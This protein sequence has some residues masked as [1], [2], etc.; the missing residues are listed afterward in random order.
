M[1]KNSRTVLFV[2]LLLI[3]LNAPESAQVSQVENVPNPMETS[4]LY[5]QDSAGV[6]GPDYIEM[7]DQVCQ[8]LYEKA[9][10]ELAV[11]T[12][13]SLE[14]ISIEEFALRLFE[15]F[16]IGKKRED[17]GI[18]ILFA[19]D[20]RE[21]RMEVG[22]GLEDVV[23]DMSASSLLDEF[24][25]P[26]F[27]EGLYGKGL[28]TTA[29]KTAEFVAAA[30]GVSLEIT[31]S[32]ALPAQVAPP[33]ISEESKPQRAKL[34]LGAGILLYTAG[35]FGIII[36]GFV[37]IL[38]RVLTKKS[39]AA[40]TKA[41]KGQGFFLTLMWIA[42]VMGPGILAN[43]LGVSLPLVLTAMASPVLG[44]IGMLKGIKWL[45]RR[46]ESY[47]A[48]CPDCGRKMN[49]V[50]EKQDDAFLS[51][52][53]RAEETAQGMDYEIWTCPG[54][55]KTSRFDIKLRKAR[56]CPQCKRRTLKTSTTTLKAATRSSGGRIRVLKKCKNPKCG[57]SKVSERDTPKISPPSSTSG[58]SSF[59]GRSS[60][61]SSS[62][63]SFGG[64]RSGGGGSSKRW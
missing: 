56:K 40:R 21:I 49:L 34:S 62:R 51:V 61:S 48:N 19:R 2:F 10:T 44:T 64:G 11:V 23:A 41:V 57:Y 47:R 26:F 59:S 17:T 12:I 54:C 3:L 4:G 55:D 32:A 20:D 43:F 63:S 58:G 15:R 31:E 33:E 24:A 53:E 8:A 14:G 50:D 5:V 9:S 25:L 28:Y 37:F 6:L 16:G 29:L 30:R 27:R 60:S 46:A 36:F 18:L 35:I 42:A 1:R 7:I 52:E 22:Y 13:A 45:R 39:K 38:L